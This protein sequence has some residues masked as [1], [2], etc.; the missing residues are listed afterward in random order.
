MDEFRIDNHKLIYHPERVA[1]W[2]SGEDVFPLYI[3]VSPCSA[4]NHRCIFCAFDYLGHRPVHLDPAVLKRFI[5]DAAANGTKSMLFSG[6]GET[7]LY[8]H[9]E[10]AVSY[11]HARGVDA[12]VTTN[13]VF[14]TPARAARLIPALSWLRVSLNAGTAGT[15]AHVH[16]TNKGDFSKVLH[17]IEQAVLLGKKKKAAC[18]IGV[19]FLLLNENYRETTILARRLKD[20]GADYLIIKPY[21]QHPLSVNRLKKGLRYEDFRKLEEQVK[22]Y[23]SRDF[24]V[25]FRAH[26]MEKL[27]GARTYR[28]CYGLP[29]YAH[30]TT[31]GDLYA[32]SSFIGDRRFCYGN[33]YEQSFR[34]I[35]Q[36]SRRK[37]FMRMM[38]QKWDTHRCREVCRL[39][40]INRY[41]WELKHPHPHVNFI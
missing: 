32:C 33:I 11:A 10:E 30:L 14:L 41:L 20:I 29:F 39:D 3:E 5:R 16:G 35:W 18:T 24:S 21:S 15:Y 22:K 8:A 19:Q 26:T 7:L 27:A 34:E 36:G 23:E 1:R 6:E 13:A 2:S 38:A 40:E 4:C 28:R 37:K 9:L 25:I 31:E 12:A 17:N